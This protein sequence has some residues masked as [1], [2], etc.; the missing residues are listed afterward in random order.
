MT[1][2]E[3]MAAAARG[4]ELLAVALLVGGFG[5]GL[6]RGIQAMRATGHA[7]EGYRELRTRFSHALLLGLEVLVAADLL[8]TVAVEPTQRSL[9]ELGAVVLIRT[10]LSF[11]IEVEIEGVA[12]WR[13]GASR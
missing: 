10:F 12:P 6:L 11:S 8:Q 5:F 9:L 7:R 13:R 3:L 4:F 1:Y 2:P